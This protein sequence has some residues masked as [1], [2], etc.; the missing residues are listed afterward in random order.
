MSGVEIR[1]CSIGDR[2][3]ACAFVEQEAG[4]RPTFTEAEIEGKRT[5]ID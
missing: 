3:C 2:S 4:K 5:Y 1:H